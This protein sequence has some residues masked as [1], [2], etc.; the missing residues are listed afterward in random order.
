M[1]QPKFKLENRCSNN[2]A[3]QLAIVKVLEVIESQQEN[4]NEHRTAVIYMDSKITLD[5]IRSAKNH[6]HLVEEIRKKAVT[7]KKKNW[8]TEFKWVRAHTGIF[9]NEIA[10]RLAK[11]A[12]QNYYVTYSRIPRSAI[13]KDTRKES[14]RKWQRQWEETMKGVITKEL[15]PSVESRLA[16]NLTLSPKVTT[17]M[18]GHGNILS[19]LTPIKIIGSPECPCKH[20]T[21]TVEHLIF[22]CNRLKN[23]G[24]KLKNSV[25]RVGNWPVSKSELTN[26]YLKQ[27]TRYV[28][29]IDLEKINY[30]N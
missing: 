28:N 6:N 29:S 12:T 15:F 21:Q 3:E 20:G 9:G 23:E 22:R 14:I 17:I 10:D 11:E 13:K 26:R 24:E 25:L 2:Q 18:T 27:F 8:K 5:S 1:E 16:V 30:S 4:H 7:L 19:D